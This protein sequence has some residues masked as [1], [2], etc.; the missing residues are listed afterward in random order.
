MI[1]LTKQ[2]YRVGLEVNL[3]AAGRANL[4]I[5]SRLLSLARIVATGGPGGLP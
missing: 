2:D 5:S 3:Q 1:R 4:K